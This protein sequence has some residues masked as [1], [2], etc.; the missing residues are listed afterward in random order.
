M[1][2]NGILMLFIQLAAGV[3]TGQS[4]GWIL[5]PGSYQ[6]SASL[7]ARLTVDSVPQTADH[8][9]GV[10]AGD[11]LRGTGQPLAGTGGLYLLTV[12]ANTV[13]GD[14]LRVE[15]YLTDRQEI[16]PAVE[17][18]V[19]QANQIW[20]NVSEPTR[21]H[22]W[23][24]G[25]IPIGLDSIPPQVAVRPNNFA[26]LDLSPYLRQWDGDSVVW[27]ATTNGSN[28]S[29]GVSGSTLDAQPNDPAWTGTQYITVTATEQTTNQYAASRVIAYSRPAGYFAPGWSGIP[30]Q[31]IGQAD[32]FALY[33]LDDHVDASYQ[34]SCLAY[35]VTVDPGFPGGNDT[36]PGW[37]VQPGIFNFAMIVTARAVF[38]P[39]YVF[40]DPGDRLAAFSGDQ[41]VG[42]AAPTFVDGKAYYFLTV[43]GQAAG[44][45][46]LRFHSAA[47]QRTYEILSPLSFQPNAVVGDLIHPYLADASP[48]RVELDSDSHV[49][50][51]TR[52]DTSWSGYLPF[53]HRVWE[54]AYPTLT[55][56][57]ATIN[58]SVGLTEVCDGIDN[59]YD[60]LVDEGVLLTFYAD[61]DGDGFGDLGHDTLACSLPP[62]FVT[63]TTDCDDTDAAIHPGATE[64][65]DDIDNDCDG[66]VD[67]ADPGFVDQTAPQV[68]CRNITR[69]L[70]ASGQLSVQPA[71]V[72]LN[73]SDD[74]GTV[75]L[76][77]VSPAQFGCADVGLRTVT[78]TVNDGNGNQSTCQGV[79][80]VQDTTLPTAL[81]QAAT[82]VLNSQGT[83]LLSAAQV[84]GGSFDNCGGGTTLS[85]GQTMFTCAHV[86]PNTVT[87]YVED[88]S[89]NMSSCDAVVTV[90]DQTAPLA[91]CKPVTVS[92][93]AN[94]QAVVTGAQVND[95]SADACGIASLQLN[96]AVF[97]CA[98]QGPNPVV[99]TVT[100]VNGN[101]ST[102]Q[103]VVTVTDQAGPLLVCQ[104]IHI[105]L[106]TVGN[107]QLL[108]IQVFD[109]QLSGDNC[110]TVQLTGVSP[111]AF[112][113]G[114]I[115]ANTVV[116]TAVDDQGNPASCQAVVTVDPYFG[117][118]TVDIIPEVC[119]ETLG[120]LTLN[121]SSIYQQLLLY[122]VDGGATFQFSPV[123]TGLSSG[124]YGMVVQA[125]GTAGCVLGPEPVVV[126]AVGAL[127]NTWTGAGD[128]ISWGQSANWS[129]GIVP[130][131]CH[132]VVVPAGAG[133]L[134][135]AG[136]TAVGNTLQ[137]DPAGVLTVETTGELLIGQE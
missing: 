23:T 61:T 104:D 63:D 110:G 94:G 67:T 124:N 127:L 137:V 5:D 19:F 25:D 20:G 69:P 12:Y 76:V 11:Q 44:P 33:D 10:F 129:L 68:S 57:T 118:L 64:I 80:T 45:L 66:L 107:A 65:C 97:G 125:P 27:S 81:C 15:A 75:N 28:F 38:T 82:M 13:S 126:P 14:T 72:Y 123:F 135:P 6:Y 62:G 96:P 100:D 70:D 83:V 8:Q 92:L 105:A 130:V 24:D 111:S 2:S 36:L 134:V 18:F 43:Y 35:A 79:V 106:D 58:Y 119:G 51:V 132:N 77:S 121:V 42:V 108:P 56:D 128:G 74:C 99:L 116:L 59:D 115:G 47:K 88:P 52:V 89:S 109:A 50:A 31:A 93:G 91:K 122:S 4:P 30:S 90:L 98:D 53:Q 112:S 7:V 17:T 34:G 60:M 55:G 41:P 101:S 78:L 40:D 113:C 87:L 37:S 85:L 73:G 46:T 103:A 54:C 102:C 49:V 22:C 136:L 29:L 32:T 39:G 26:P 71:E 95:N 48:L 117:P 16:H 84:D 114:N 3:L 1:K 9:L 120:G 86:G 21:L 133:V 131:L